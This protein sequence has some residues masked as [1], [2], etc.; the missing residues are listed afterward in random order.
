MGNIK[1]YLITKAVEKVV[2]PET[3]A[4]AA[5]VV[6]K[7]GIPQKIAKNVAAAGAS[8]ATRIP[9]PL[10]QAGARALEHGDKFIP[11]AAREKVVKSAAD[12]VKPETLLKFDDVLGKVEPLTI[13]LGPQSM[14]AFIAA[15]KALQFGAKHGTS[16]E[17]LAAQAIKAS[18]KAK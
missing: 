2:T 6:Q 7:S 5:N 10:K 3:I 16:T 15:R 17:N 1:S 13:G 8:A 14:A 9:G 12:A 11:A 18:L 4:K